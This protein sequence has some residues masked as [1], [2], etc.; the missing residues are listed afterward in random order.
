MTTL[1]YCFSKL[2]LLSNEKPP[3][4]ME[5]LSAEIGLDGKLKSGA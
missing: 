3:L 5:G 2:I 1:V 4:Q